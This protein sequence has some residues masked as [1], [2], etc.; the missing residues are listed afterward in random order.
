MMMT[1][2]KAIGVCVFGRLLQ[3]VSGALTVM[4][5]GLHDNGTARSWMGG[6]EP[7]DITPRF[8]IA[9][10]SGEGVVGRWLARCNAY[11]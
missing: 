5:R 4:R 3:L 2:T 8:L 11:T 9:S 7:P 6:C 1:M 10:V